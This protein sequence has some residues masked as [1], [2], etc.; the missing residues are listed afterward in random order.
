M[1]GGTYLDE[2]NNKERRKKMRSAK[3]TGCFPYLMKTVCYFEVFPDGK[4]VQLDT[5]NEKWDACCRAKIGESNIYAVWPGRWR[6]DLFTIDDLET[7]QKELQTLFRRRY[8]Q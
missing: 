4:T 1:P 2:I 5:A 8:I 6:S 3:E 7:F